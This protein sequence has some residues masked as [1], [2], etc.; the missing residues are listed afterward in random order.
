MRSLLKK[1]IPRLGAKWSRRI[2]L[3]YG[4]SGPVALTG[5]T[6]LLA[7]AGCFQL[8]VDKNDSC[9]LLC[10]PSGGCPGSFKCLV[11][12]NTRQGLCASPET[13]MC[14]PLTG[15][16]GMGG[17][18]D[19][20]DAGG[21]AGSV[22]RMDA[23]AD[24]TDGGGTDAEAGTSGP[25]SMLCHNGSCLSL[26]PDVQ[27]NLVLLLWPSNLPAVGATVPVWAD[28]S[29]QGND[30]H[31]LAPKA[32]PV[33]IPDGVHLDP[34]QVGTGFVVVNSPSLD[35]GSGDFAV[36]VVA[37]LSSSTTP[38]SFFRKSEGA[39]TSQQISL[40]WILS[41]TSSAVTGQP[42]G[43]VDGTTVPAST[44]ISQPS[45]AAYAL[46]RSTD[47]VELHVNGVVLGSSDLPTPGLST[48]NA[49]DLYLGVNGMV[50][51]PADSIE[52][53]VAIRGSI[54]STELNQLEGFMRDVFA[55]SAP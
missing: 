33:V 30:A 19:R 41:S 48:T 55:K 39:R 15:G 32:L 49:A 16:G 9:R 5:L 36:I 13:S 54:G 8:N 1:N 20:M 23:S 3:P 35:F 38:L 50:G 51:S 10:S 6:A 52:A 12:P 18:V 14:Q 22:D 42:Q 34:T 40:D 27:A 44:D 53:V 29:G 7:L 47:Q 31:A 17:S 25:P 24:R 26:P 28:Q 2:R 21:T 11:D 37:G 43:V 45:V 46:Y 4:M